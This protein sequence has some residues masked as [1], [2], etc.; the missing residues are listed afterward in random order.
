MLRKW[1]L[2]GASILLASACVEDV[3]RVHDDPLRTRPSYS[4]VD[5]AFGDGNP[6]VFF[7][8]PLAPDRTYTGVFDVSL[9]SDV[10]F[11]ICEWQDNTCVVEVARFTAAG[12]YAERLRI[13]DEQYIAQ[14]NTSTSN[15]K[16][17]PGYRLLILWRSAELAHADLYIVEPG[18]ATS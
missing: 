4:V 2:V 18:P 13:D 11:Q 17:G 15:V 12:T 5:G 14:W 1:Y 10:S 8:P 6:Y 9:L 16:N 3:T 7:R